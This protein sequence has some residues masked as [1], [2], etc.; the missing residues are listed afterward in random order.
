MLSGSEDLRTPA[1]GGAAH[2]AAAGRDGTLVRVPGAGHAVVSQGIA[3][4]RRALTRFFAGAAVGNPCDARTVAGPRPA[5]RGGVRG[6]GAAVAG[7]A[8]ATVEDAIRTAAIAGPLF[9]PYRGG[10][11]RGGRFCAHPGEVANDGRRPL[12]VTL[13]SDRFARG[14]PVTG[15][16]V[17]TRGRLSALSVRVGGRGR[18]VLDGRTLRGRRVRARLAAS[19]LR[20]PALTVPAAVDATAC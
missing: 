15:S 19:R 9:E 17:V 4:V 20:M 1:G 13:R 16:V 5:R 8:L 7:A 3:C 12:L 14:L 18:L 11:L 2:D 10:G 6:P